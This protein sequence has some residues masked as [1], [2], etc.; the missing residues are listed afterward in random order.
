MNQRIMIVEDER[1]VALDLK[2]SLT[3]L[4][5]EVVGMASRGGDA[6]ALAGTLQPDII[7]MDINLEDDIDGTEAARAIFQR[8]QLPVIFLTAYAEE[9]T[10]ARA[11]E[12]LPYGYLLKPFDLR[13]LK[14]TL[15]M[16][17]AR[18]NTELGLQ[19]SEARLRLA[20]KA[21]DLGLWEW[22]RNQDKL[23]LSGN[24]AL[25]LSFENGECDGIERFI[26]RF[27]IPS[28]NKLRQAIANGGA[29]NLT[30]GYVIPNGDLTWIDFYADFRNQEE[31]PSSQMIGVFLN[32]TERCRREEQL[33]QAN[34]VFDTAAEGII[35][36]DEHHR[37][38]STNPAFTRLTGYRQEEVLGQTPDHLMHQRRQGDSVTPWSHLGKQEPAWHGEML[39]V[40]KDGTHFT[41]WQHVSIVH[42]HG[43]GNTASHYVIAFS[44]I[45]AIRQAEAQLNHL[46]YHDPLTGLGNRNQL[47]DRLT[48]ELQTAHLH[49]H[50]LGLLFID[51]D[52]FKL[53]NDTL[54]HSAG[55]QLLR[56]L[57]DRLRSAIRSNDLL[58]RQGGDEFLI[59]VPQVQQPQ[60]LLTLAEKV[61]QTIRPPIPLSPEPVSISASIGI[62]LFP[63]DASTPEALLQAADSAMYEAKS[64]G[65]NRSLLYSP[66]MAQRSMN[67]LRL[68]QGLA[69]ALDRS[70]LELHYQ[71]IHSLQQSQPP[72]VEAL[73]RWRHPERG[74]IAPDQFIPIAE[75]SGLIEPIGQWVMRE[76]CEQGA[77]WLDQG[78]PLS[79]LAVNVSVRELRAHDYAAQVAAI[80]KQTGFPPHLLELEVTES[81]MQQV[82][83]SL[84]KFAELKQ[85]GVT[86]AIDDFGTGFS[87]LSLLKSLPIDRIKIDR[88]FVQ[89]I[90][91][92]RHSCELC[93]TIITLAHNLD[94][95]VTAEGIETPE[96]LTF[97]QSLGCENGQGYL[98][99]PPMET[100]QFLSYWSQFQQRS[101]QGYPKV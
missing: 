67:K 88:S 85:L 28:Q 44:D 100:T 38:I 27:L 14:A 1:I 52:G 24:D 68:E 66:D 79:R 95:T 99:N 51:L 10:L 32:V 69:Q 8:W 91:H 96:Q 46:A 15:Q 54:G 6:I 56:L 49:Q 89:P 75:E 23:H 70:E 43:S 31:G 55:D 58:T 12:S 93:R 84:R 35:I 57:A 17:M 76:A 21:A 13:E 42:G 90:P 18:R 62:A 74:I 63:D 2:N 81:I 33:P 34:V 65:R 5:Y 20:I 60:E 11:E 22:N 9:K 39:F 72:G 59:L 3:H 71:P 61:L 48:I 29:F 77:R 16:A 30:L 41:S 37:I 92:D 98:F 83:Q 97:L 19:E 7:L 64:Q 40:R 86:I 53:I 87:S 101:W 25:T 4:G 45:S 36:M 94:L 50:R 26:E 80:L 78:L 73:L 82:D 47:Q